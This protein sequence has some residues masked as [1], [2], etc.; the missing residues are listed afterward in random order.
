MK[1]LGIMAESLVATKSGAS[2]YQNKLDTILDFIENKDYNA[3][4]V[5]PQHQLMRDQRRLGKIW[6]MLRRLSR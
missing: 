4:D 1:L 5:E 2:T 3:D 6:L